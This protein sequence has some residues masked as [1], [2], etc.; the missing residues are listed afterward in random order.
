MQVADEA[1]TAAVMMVRFYEKIVDKSRDIE[2]E[3]LYQ[4]IVDR[5]RDLRKIGENVAGCAESCKATALRTTAHVIFEQA[6]QIKQMAEGILS[7]FMLFV[8]GTGNY[9]KSTLVNAVI[10][11]RVA[12]MDALPK[13]WKIDIFTSALPAGRVRFKFLTGEEKI[14]SEKEAKAFLTE[15][16]KKR[17]RSEREIDEEYNRR[18]RNLSLEARQEL[19]ELLRQ[20]K[21]YKSPV[22]EVHWSCAL[23]TVLRRFTIVDTPGMF[24]ILDDR[25]YN[26]LRDFYHKADG[27]LWM[28]D[29]NVVA[30]RNPQKLIE[31]LKMT[32]DKVGGYRKNIVAVLNRI[33]Q[34]NDG[35]DGGRVLKEA[36]RIY[37]SYFLDIIPF[38][39]RKALEAVEAYDADGIEKSGLSALMRAIDKYFLSQ[40]ISLRANVRVNSFRNYIG[41][42]SQRTLNFVIALKRDEERRLSLKHA[43]SSSIDTQAEK[44][45]KLVNASLE[46]YKEDVASRIETLAAQLF[47]IQED[48]RRSS[49]ASN[50][51]F[52]RKELLRISRFLG[53]HIQK[54]A[55]D[56][57]ADFSRKSVF[58]QFPHLAASDDIK[59]L[60]KDTVGALDFS[61]TE[62]DTSGDQLLAGLLSGGLALALLGP[63]GLV[64]GV[65]ALTSFGRQ[66][67]IKLK[68]PGLKQ[69]LN[70]QLDTFVNQLTQTLNDAINTTMQQVNTEVTTLREQSFSMLYGPS[71]RV[72]EILH[73]IKKIPAVA[74]KPF[75]RIEA[76]KIIAGRYKGASALA[77]KGA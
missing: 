39:A 54:T 1:S 77:S 65:L 18:S 2:R 43:L 9:G 11:S 28:L 64:V 46:D 5:S 6:E 63:I 37:G 19:K 3:L 68:L 50:R 49:F 52:N 20:Q 41:D 34:V 27:V 48:D 40:A 57:H 21:L 42:V 36:Q 23:S 69:K 72:D 4:E 62:F 55:N 53:Q 61:E 7:P 24:Q 29:A 44:L 22:S 59:D 13:T 31:D 32:L 74:Q 25:V 17:E 47:D 38:S 58:V 10:G 26:D 16:E 45:V 33:D 51:I 8:V 70:E 14:M 35:A 12:D 30:A 66:I 75:T 56:I 71:Y 67:I 15:E 60:V 76:A 73:H